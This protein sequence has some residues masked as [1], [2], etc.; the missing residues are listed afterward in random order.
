MLMHYTVHALYGTVGWV[1]F[2][3]F[4]IFSKSTTEICCF[5]FKS[6]ENFIRNFGPVILSHSLYCIRVNKSFYH[7]VDF[8]GIKK[9]ILRRFHKYKLTL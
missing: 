4:Y 3:L 5:P 9:T 2:W 7:N 1:E 6:K 8:M